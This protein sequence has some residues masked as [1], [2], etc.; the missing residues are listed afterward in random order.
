M[1]DNVYYGASSTHN[2][3][4]LVSD[5]EGFKVSIPN[6]INLQSV[7]KLGIDIEKASL[8]HAIRKYRS[9]DDKNHDC[10]L[11][12]FLEWYLGGSDE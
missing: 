4:K 3:Y 9:M 12:A 8:R 10:S 11:S 2:K 6:D 7:F 1:S 5:P